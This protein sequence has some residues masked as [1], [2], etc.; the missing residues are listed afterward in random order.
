M[1]EGGRLDD[2]KSMILERSEFELVMTS[3][4]SSERRK[5]GGGG[6]GKGEAGEGEGGD[7]E[8]RREKG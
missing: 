3:A 1:Q 5:G 4:L 6:G 2:K 8:G 7:G